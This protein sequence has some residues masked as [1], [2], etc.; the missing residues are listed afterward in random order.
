MRLRWESGQCR[1][2][3]FWRIGHRNIRFMYLF[4]YKDLPPFKTIRDEVLP[5]ELIMSTVSL[6]IDYS[7]GAQKHFSRI[8]WQTGLTLL[9]AIE[10]SAAIPPGAAIHY[11]SD[12]VGHAIGLVIDEMPRGDTAASAWVIWVNAKP[13]K[14][15]LGTDT[16]F[17]FHPDEREANLV[18][19]GDH[20]LIKLS[21]G[22]DTPA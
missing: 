17:G 13:F 10:A 22:A 9:G 19:A 20:I 11:G 16:S 15:R 5:R 4:S 6:T 7:N 12:R 21:V 14:S 8:P 1:V 18:N 3:T 2:V